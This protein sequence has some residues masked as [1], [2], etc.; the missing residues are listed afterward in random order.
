MDKTT[1]MIVCLTIFPK[2]REI[3]S[4]YDNRATVGLWR[5]FSWI[6]A[7]RLWVLTYCIISCAGDSWTAVLPTSAGV[8][9]DEV[10]GLICLN[11]LKQLHYRPKQ[12]QIT[13]KYIKMYPNHVWNMNTHTHAQPLLVR[14][15]TCGHVANSVGVFD[16]YNIS[17]LENPCPLPRLCVCV[18]V[19]ACA[20]DLYIRTWGVPS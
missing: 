18:C 7:D 1:D 6:P 12:K 11:H 8:L 19:C 2:K 17:A 9:H 20:C 15:N 3:L 14:H 10:K 4:V 5:V 13:D 16:P